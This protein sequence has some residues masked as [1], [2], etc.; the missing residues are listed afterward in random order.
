MATPLKAK[1]QSNKTLKLSRQ[2]KWRKNPVPWAVLLLLSLG[3][4]A[5]FVFPDYINWMTQK[6]GID[7]L[8]IENQQLETD[9][10]T[11]K[12]VRSQEQDKFD[13]LAKNTI[14]IEEQRFPEQV[15]T[16]LVASILEIYALQLNL[17]RR[18][19]VDLKSVSFSN[20]RQSETA[21]AFE[22]PAT[23]SLS[24][25]EDS[26][27]RFMDF[28]QT[29]EYDKQLTADTIS[30]E[31]KGETAAL[32]YLDSNLLPLAHI[33]SINLT[34]DN[35]NSDFPRRV[36]SAQIQVAFFSQSE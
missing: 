4:G 18:T 33:R 34:E 31:N 9:I 11:A 19:L 36:Y 10:D 12:K 14:S 30:A 23:I 28:L 13:Q 17:S 26:L 22:L 5:L 6:G 21:N 35:E 29:G 3:F 32:E 7:D 8:I 25:D 20:T 1:K 2:Q 24:I 15:N 27:E 16:N